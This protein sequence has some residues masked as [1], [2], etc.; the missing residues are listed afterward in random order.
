MDQ[1]KK[2]SRNVV[3]V[4]LITLLTSQWLSTYAQT[5]NPG[6]IE[7]SVM[8]LPETKYSNAL[9]TLKNPLSSQ[10]TR[11]S[12]GYAFLLSS[13]LDTSSKRFS[14]WSGTVN[15]NY[16]NFNNKVNV[17]QLVPARLLFSEFGL[18]HLSTLKNNWVAVQGLSFGL[19]TDLVQITTH[20][21]FINANIIFI[22]KYSPSFS[23]GLGVFAYNA[24]S[25]PIVLPG[26]FVQWQTSGAFKLLVNLPTEISIA[27]EI[28]KDT[29]LKLAFR[30]KN[31]NYDVSNPLAKQRRALSYW[32]LPIG[33]ELKRK[34]RK[35]DYGI[36]SGIMALRSFQFN[37]RGISNMFRSTPA[38]MLKA[39][40]FIN[41]TVQFHL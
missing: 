40:F 14:S 6:N 8:Y 3:R 35:I 37:E 32:E 27:S 9:D 34:T 5:L 11:F 38:H 28:R 23:L 26:F 36:G 17:D 39:N 31:I 20:D 25:M 13:K 1:I 24:I 10:Q 12:L 22:K 33:L 18:T 19:N 15:L 21:L 29:E 41:A 4:I 30:P 2:I 7:A 16:T